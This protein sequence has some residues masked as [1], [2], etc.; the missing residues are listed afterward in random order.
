MLFEYNFLANLLI[1]VHLWRGIVY[2]FSREENMLAI[3]S[4]RT[5]FTIF[6]SLDKAYFISLLLKAFQKI[7]IVDIWETV[8][9]INV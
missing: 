7:F 3:Y 1:F 4:Q 9:L 6:V 5:I 8:T 2:M